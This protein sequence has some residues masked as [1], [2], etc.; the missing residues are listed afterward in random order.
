MGWAGAL[1]ALQPATSLA[2]KNPPHLCAVKNGCQPVLLSTPSIPTICTY[3][4]SIWMSVVVCGM[5][6]HAIVTQNTVDEEKE[7]QRNYSD[8]RAFPYTNSG[9]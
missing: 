9:R 2:E 8:G 4:G 1:L 7:E 3:A 5:E 6:R